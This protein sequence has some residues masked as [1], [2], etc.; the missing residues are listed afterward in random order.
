MR[1]DAAVPEVSE[2]LTLLL[3]LLLLGLL[4]LVLDA[5]LLFG[6]VVR[7]MGVDTELDELFNEDI[8]DEEVVLVASVTLVVPFVQATKQ[9]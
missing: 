3:E 5:V 7:D 4:L 2:E 8:D 1:L 6:E 9:F